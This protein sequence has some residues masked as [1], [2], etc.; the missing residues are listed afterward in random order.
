MDGTGRG[1]AVAVGCLSVV[2]GS[3]TALWLPPTIAA[4]LG[5]LALLRVCWLEDNIRGDLDAAD[6][7]PQ[8]YRET[9]R[10]QSRL[11]WLILGLWDDEDAVRCPRL[12][13]SQM[14]LQVHAWYAALYGGVAACIALGAGV[15]VAGVAALAALAAACRRVERFCAVDW[16]LCRGVALPDRMLHDRGLLA[17]LVV[18]GAAPPR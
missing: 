17:R 10:L 6:D 14:R 7:V 2:A 9:Q 4:A 18:R 8:S 13:A 5:L 1:T 3:A 12:L 16:L 15:S 11:R